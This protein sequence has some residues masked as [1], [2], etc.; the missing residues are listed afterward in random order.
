ML[1]AH[2]S[3][4]H[5]FAN[6]SETSVV[7]ADAADAARKAA[8]VKLTGTGTTCTIRFIMSDMRHGIA[9][10]EELEKSAPDIADA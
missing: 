3:D 5:V 7:R 10:L 9:R 6:A 8:L 1:I 4:F 2:I